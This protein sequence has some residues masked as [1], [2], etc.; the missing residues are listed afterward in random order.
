MLVVLPPLPSSEF[1]LSTKFALL[2]LLTTTTE[3]D[4]SK[5]DIAPI[6]IPFKMPIFVATPNSAPM[7]ELIATFAITIELLRLRRTKEKYRLVLFRP[8][9]SNILA[10]HNRP[11][12]KHSAITPN[13]P[14]VSNC[15][16]SSTKRKPKGPTNA[17]QTKK[18][19]KSDDG[20]L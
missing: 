13:S 17:P 15:T 20:A 9:F 3:L 7:K 1:A 12:E 14:N 19:T 4:P 16:G 2:D 6:T 5:T 18:P 11:T 10:S 8:I